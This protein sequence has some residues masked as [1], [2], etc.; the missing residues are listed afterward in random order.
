VVIS[1]AMTVN[2]VLQ[3]NVLGSLY[4]ITRL[5][6]RWGMPFKT[7]IRVR[8]GDSLFPAPSMPIFFNHIPLGLGVM[9]H[10]YEFTLEDYDAY[11]EQRDGML[12]SFQ[13]QAA[14]LAGG[15]LWRLARDSN[16]QDTDVSIGTSGYHTSRDCVELE[17]GVYVDDTLSIHQ[18]DVICGVYRVAPGKQTCSIM[19]IMTEACTSREPRGRTK[20]IGVLFMVAVDDNMG[21]C[22]SEPPVLEHG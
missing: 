8:D 1:D 5:L 11:T 19:R 3:S 10:H 16:K 9:P 14:L 2:H 7:L 13:G 15:L 20:P 22:R 6:L 21:E 12:S 18:Q 17:D 4:E